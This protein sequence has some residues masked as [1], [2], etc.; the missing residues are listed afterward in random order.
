M[1]KGFVA[2][3]CGVALALALFMPLPVYANGAGDFLGQVLGQIALNVLVDSAFPSHP[4]PPPPAPLPE[5]VLDPGH[6]S[7]LKGR[8]LQYSHASE[9]DTF[10]VR[11]FGRSF[12]TLVGGDAKDASALVKQDGLQDPAPDIQDRLVQALVARYGLRDAGVA[13]DTVPPAPGVLLKVVTT[14]WELKSVSINPLHIVYG[15]GH[16]GLY[17]HADFSLVDRHNGEIIAMGYCD[18]SPAVKGAPTFDQSLAD[19]GRLIKD[20]LQTAAGGCV[21]DIEGEYLHIPKPLTDN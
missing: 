15:L 3:C 16:Y 14:H 17:Y 8:D 5:V 10:R 18:E 6:E 20:M 21:S 13:P 19:G 4:G 12:Y 11:D 1:P 9:S 7:D 2:H